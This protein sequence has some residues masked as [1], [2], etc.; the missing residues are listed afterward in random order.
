MTGRTVIACFDLLSLRKYPHKP[1]LSS[2]LS[3]DVYKSLLTEVYETE[4][5]ITAKG[6]V[7]KYHLVGHSTEFLKK[8]AVENEFY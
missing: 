7:G 5:V 3:I 6:G 8:E 1:S 2:R 4:Y